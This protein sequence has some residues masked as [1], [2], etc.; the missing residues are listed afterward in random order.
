MQQSSLANLI[1][2]VG[3]KTANRDAIIPTVGNRLLF[4]Q[5]RNPLVRLIGQFSSWAMAKSAQTNAMM[6]RVESGDLRTAIGMLSA[7]TAFGAV[8][9]LRDYVKR[10]EWDTVDNL[11]DD[12]QTWWSEAAMLSGNLGWLS[13]TMVNS[14]VRFKGG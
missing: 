8:K 1:D 7:L 11:E 3:T 13:Q 10:G 5:T 14:F 9:D 12:P 4:T 6:T 2:R